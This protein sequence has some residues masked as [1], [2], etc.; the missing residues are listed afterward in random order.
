MIPRVQIDA[1]TGLR[2]VAAWFVVLYHI[3]EAFAPSL[4]APVIAAFAK[5]YLAVDL[6][7]V[8]SGFVLWITWGQRFADEGLRAALPFIRKR[9]ARVWPLHAVVLTATVAFALVIAATGRP[10]PA[11]YR[12]E[13]LPLHYLLV[14]NWGFT[15]DLAWNDPS[16]SISTELA[17]Y[18]L[19]PLVAVV[20]APAMRLGAGWRVA[21]AVA[22]TVAISVALDRYF[23][24]HGAALLGD[25]IAQLGLVRC[26]ALFACGMLMAIVWQV[27]RTAAL[28]AGVAALAFGAW[29]LS[30]G[31]ETLAVPLMFATLVPF[32][33]ATSSGSG[34]LL[35]S[36]LFVYLG[37]ISYSTYLVHFLLWTLFKIAFVTDARDVPVALG[38]LFL[39]LTFVASVALYRIVEV[40]ARDWLSGAKSAHVEGD[41]D[42]AE[43]YGHATGLPPHDRLR[44]PGP[45]GHH[46]QEGS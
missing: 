11:T 27:S 28:I 41:S 7:F 35:A 14:Q 9:I 38:A 17:A 30:G 24:A 16:W 39:A 3:R 34:N 5:G 29:W 6:F 46:A 4:P 43:Q 25:A 40:P 15:R 2:G 22:A 13:E 37:E 26:L 1:L 21:C 42:G 20:I 44:R 33:A 32:I 8:L 36:R 31:R 18:L 12:W 19:F 45:A 23:A 10:L